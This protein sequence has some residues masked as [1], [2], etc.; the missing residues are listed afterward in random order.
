VAGSTVHPLLSWGSLQ[1][2]D[3]IEID[4]SGNL[5]IIKVPKTQK[6]F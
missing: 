1:P 6:I 2:E 4:K 5:H 3:L